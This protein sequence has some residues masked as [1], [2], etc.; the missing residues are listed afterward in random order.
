MSR[1]Y[2]IIRA[3]QTSLNS[4]LR[5]MNRFFSPANYL[6]I[7]ISSSTGLDKWDTHMSCE[8]GTNMAAMW[9]LS[10]CAK[11][12]FGSSILPSTLFS[13]TLNLCSYLR[14]ADQVSQ[15]SQPPQSFHIS[16]SVRVHIEWDGTVWCPF[17]DGASRHINHDSSIATCSVQVQTITYLRVY[18]PHLDF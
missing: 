8:T 2:I 9:R 16:Q 3:P 11:K 13:D 6:F 17:T 12:L 18:K 7:H 10:R 15:K 14:L 4:K 5:E 1:K